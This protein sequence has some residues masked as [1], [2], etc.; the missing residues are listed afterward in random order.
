MVA[1]TTYPSTKKP[2]YI[3][4][5]FSKEKTLVDNTKYFYIKERYLDFDRKVFSKVYI[6]IRILKFRGLKLI[7]S[8]DVFPL[9][10]YL[11]EK[12]IKEDLIIYSRKF[13][14]LTRV[15]HRY[16]NSIVF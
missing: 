5:D 6:V 3:K 15:C 11:N 9:K 2:R 1:Y 10:S 8:L 13:Y 14:A 7:T 12:K 4:Y 16:Y